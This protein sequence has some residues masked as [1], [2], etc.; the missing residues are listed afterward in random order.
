MAETQEAHVCSASV[1]VALPNPAY[2]SSWQLMVVWSAA[3]HGYGVRL[4]ARQPLG[5]AL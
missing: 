2:P 3:P 4:S 5:R 1:T